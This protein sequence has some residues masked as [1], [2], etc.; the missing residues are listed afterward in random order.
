MANSKS[1]NY[2]MGTFTN[3]CH[4]LQRLVVRH[5]LV[6]VPFVCLFL[7]TASFC[8]HP[9]KANAIKKQKIYLLNR[10]HTYGA[11]IDTTSTSLKTSYAYTRATMRVEK[12]NVTL[13]LVPTAYVVT[14]GKEREYLSEMYNKITVNSLGNF[15]VEPLLRITT[16]PRRKRPMPNFSRYLTPDIYNETI[17]G[18]TLL[19]PF[20][21]NNFRFYTYKIDRTVNDTVTLRF[22]PKRKNTQL[23][24]GNA[25]VDYLTGRIFSVDFRGEFDMVHFWV[26]M[27]MNDHGYASLFPSR[28]ESLFLFK[29]VGNR[30]SGHYISYYGL[31]NAL[32]D[33]I[34]PQKVSKLSPEVVE[35]LMTI[36]RPEPLDELEQSIYNRK[37]EKLHQDS[38]RAS[39]DTV[40]HKKNWMKT[41][42]WD[43]IGDNVLNRVKS[44]FGMNNRGYVRLN[45]VLNPLYMGYDHRRGFT[46]KIDVRASYQFNDNSEISGRFKG[47]YAFKQKQFYFRLPLYYFFNKRRNGYLKFE[48]GNGNHISNESVRKDIIKNHINAQSAIDENLL[49]EF[50]QHDSR[51]VL[52][53][54]FGKHFG[55]QIGALYQR[56]EA[57]HKQAFHA[58]GW[59][60]VYSSFAPLVELQFRPWGWT[61][62]IITA[63]YDRA[64]KGALKTNSEYERVE[65]NSE[66][67]HHINQLQSLQ[68]RVGG[69][70]YTMK[71]RRAYFLNYENFRENNIPGGWNDDWSGEFELLRS[72][73]YNTSD[74]YLRAN[75][76]Y[77]SP[78]L[79]LSWLPLIGHYMEMERIYVSAL[80]VSNVHPYIELG[81]GFTTRWFSTGFFVSNGHGNRTIGCKFGFE[82]FRHW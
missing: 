1:Y 71:G 62:P 43:V 14:L 6:H 78:L 65:I 73:T 79:L 15:K 39:Q 64:I 28:C 2:P 13:K 26:S 82:L 72:S 12:R 25:K 19:S 50:K 17:V 40:K 8:L 63:D 57:V 45:P 60:S 59:T 47:G 77:E 31:P 80:D 30:V 54:D 49:N 69:G 32:G 81:Y 70:F 68:M 3:A 24:S 67:I 5:L 23:V 52:N 61:G 41:V 44:N 10:I 56:M 46:Y 34:S 38:I 4:N 76:S 48:I 29:F 55:F 22:T 7:L 66:Y 74:Y 16:I 51:L 36:V 21:P 35:K 53:Y 27:E 11:T 9:T 37:T 58:F 42:L 18:N 20:F 33:S 75:V